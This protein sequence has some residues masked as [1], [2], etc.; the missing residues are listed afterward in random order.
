MLL[1]GKIILISLTVLLFIFPNHNVI[2]AQSILLS[3][4]TLYMGQIPASST[5]VREIFISNIDTK[6]LVISSLSLSNNNG[7]QILNNPGTITIKFLESITLKIEFSP[8]T[9]GSFESQLSIV[10]NAK[11]GPSS[12]L[13]Q[14]NGTGNSKPTFERI[15]GL[16]DGTGLSSVSQTSDGG[17]ILGGSATQPNADYSD[18]YIAKTDSFGYLQWTKVYGRNYNDGIAKI[19]Q[20]SDGGYIVLGNTSVYS[21]G[22]VDVYLAKLDSNGNVI[23]E[24]TYGGSGDDDASSMVKTSDGY[25]IV[26]STTSFG[27]GSSDIYVIRVD[28]SGNMIW[29]KNYGGSGGDTGSDIVETKDGNYAIVGTTSSFNAQAFDF[30]LIKIDGNGNKLWD[31]LYGGSDWDEGHSIAELKDGSLVLV[32]FA[33]GFGAGARDIFLIKTDAEGNEI[34]Y[35]AFGGIYQDNG[36]CV[37]AT[38]DGIVLAGTISVS[39]Q[40][41]DLYIIKTDFDGNEIWESS[42][43][44]K[45]NESASGLIINNDGH[46][47]IAGSTSSYSEST[48]AYFINANS[49]GKVTAIKDEQFS[50]IPVS[51]K[52]FQNYPNPFNPSTIIQ[53]EIPQNGLVT[54]KVYDELGRVIKTLVNQYQNKG[55]HEINFNAANLSSGIYFYQL[56]T[57]LGT[58]TKKMI[59]LK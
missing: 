9:T 4:D 17:Y 55:N 10:S 14:G 45:D 21:T 23:W 59:L 6:D 31:K 28:N 38:S 51:F 39:V 50:N 12:L 22:N 46:I 48:S 3:P 57:K 26:G 8:S 34:W 2:E 35:K 32:G 41:N 52:L 20:T 13:I 16:A 56:N 15:F 58:K 24:K 43:G 19:L 7:F 40:K 53:Y 37:V 25:M 33:V 5:A 29:Q 54:L 27:D 42:Y 47:I 11:S 44:G 30:Y 36:S 18:F 49:Q 1:K